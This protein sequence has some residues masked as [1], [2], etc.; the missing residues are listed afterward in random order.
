MTTWRRMMCIGVTGGVLCL[1]AMFSTD[2]RMSFDI[3]TG[4]FVYAYSI[5]GVPLTTRRETTEISQGLRKFNA[6][7]AS[8]L[9]WLDNRGVVTR[10]KL[11]SSKGNRLQAFYRMLI[12]GLEIEPITDEARSGILH[13]AYQDVIAGRDLDFNEL[14]PPRP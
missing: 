7:H 12:L 8:H 1:A 13:R 11:P 5:F 6:V 14:L 2:V 3:G 10:G 4:D 9:V